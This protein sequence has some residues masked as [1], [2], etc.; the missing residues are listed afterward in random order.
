MSIKTSETP[1]FRKNSYPGLPPLCS[2][3]FRVCGVTPV[4]TA[5]DPVLV[6]HLSGLLEIPGIPNPRGSSSLGSPVW[7]QNSSRVSPVGV[8]NFWALGYPWVPLVH[9]PNISRLLEFPPLQGHVSGSWGPP[10]WRSPCRLLSVPQLRYPRSPLS[11][12]SP[13][14]TE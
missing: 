2:L 1:R 4:C 10:I 5:A 6:S 8:K 3:T 11:N 9:A 13:A 7:C 12:L 14:G